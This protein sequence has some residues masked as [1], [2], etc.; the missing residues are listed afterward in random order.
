MLAVQCDHIRAKELGNNRVTDDALCNLQ[1]LKVSE[2]NKTDTDGTGRQKRERE[3]TLED[4]DLPGERWWD[5]PIE[6][7]HARKKQRSR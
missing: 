6:W 4:E 1:W 5:I 7:I 3:L 2:Q